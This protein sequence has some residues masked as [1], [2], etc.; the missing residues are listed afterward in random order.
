VV[1]PTS[2]DLLEGMATT[3]A[4]RRYR[5]EPIAEADLATMFFAATRAPSGSNSQGFRFIVL[6][7]G[8]VATQAKALLGGAFRQQWAAKRRAEGTDAD[9]EPDSRLAR[10]L[11]AMDTFVE[12]FE[13]T[14]V[15]VIA[16]LV[17]QSAP[18]PREGASIYPACQNLFLAARA[19]GYG[20]V[21]AM[22]HTA[23]EP[24][25][26]ALL[27]IP[28]GVAISATIPLGRP[29][30][31]HGPVRRRPLQELVFEEGWGQ[32][33]AWAVDP[34]GTR[35]SRGNQRRTAWTGSLDDEAAVVRAKQATDGR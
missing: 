16:C 31:R 11:A 2:L 14:P 18:T 6:R 22:W 7:D 13:S 35:F 25:L 20:G 24:E 27:G 17:R 28:D 9:V 21:F 19:L 12:N 8:P 26:R 4:I 33:A 15:V 3:R 1:A 32:P 10:A 29:L 30:G 34:P 23:V 5:R